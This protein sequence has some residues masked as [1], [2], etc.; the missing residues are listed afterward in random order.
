MPAPIVLIVDPNANRA[1]RLEAYLSTAFDVVVC[2]SAREAAALARAHRPAAV[3]ASLTQD[4]GNGLQVGRRLHE[5][6][7]QDDRLVIVYGRPDGQ[8]LGE[9]TR[10]KLAK[11]YAVDRLMTDSQSPA[12]LERLIRAHLSRLAREEVP[13]EIPEDHVHKVLSASRPDVG[14]EEPTWGELLKRDATPANVARLLTKDIG[15]SGVESEESWGELLRSD[16]TAENLKKLLGRR[17][18]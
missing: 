2:A 9:A 10:E 18:L 15:W 1:A 17:V 7:R 16:V 13:A 12:D 5:R 4:H 8:R 11:A 6:A 14:P 3:L